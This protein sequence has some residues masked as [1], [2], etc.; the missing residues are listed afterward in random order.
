MHWKELSWLLS[1]PVMIAFSYFVTIYIVKKY[2]HR[3]E[4]DTVEAEKE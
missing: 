1:W 2:E 3:L 4:D